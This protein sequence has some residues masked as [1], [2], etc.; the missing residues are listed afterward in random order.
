MENLMNHIQLKYKSRRLFRASAIF[1]A[2]F[3]AIVLSGCIENYGRIKR[4]P[5]ITQAFQSYEVEPDYKYY[6]YGL[7]SYPYAIIGIDPAYHVNSR[8]W[9]EIDPE[10]EQ[11]RKMVF[12][13][14]DADHHSSITG[15][16]ILSPTGEKVGLW[17][18]SI[19]FVAVRFEEN[20]RIAVMPDTPFIRGS[21]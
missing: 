16:S 1:G 18:S 20:N 19:W 8:V 11:F 9:R 4:N 10:T 5:E 2:L 14:W 13:V 21:R 7:P 17:Y 12:R 3:A 15:A 6:Y